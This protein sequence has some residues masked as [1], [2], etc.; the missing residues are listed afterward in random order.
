MSIWRYGA[1][2]VDIFFGLSGLLYHPAS[3]S[4]V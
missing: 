4:G 2:G 1:F 3:A